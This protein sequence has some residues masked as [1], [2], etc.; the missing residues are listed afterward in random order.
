MSRSDATGPVATFD[1]GSR[2]GAASREG[3]I[4]FIGTATVLVR[5]GS[6]CFLTDPNFLHAGQRAPLGYGLH[7]TRRTDPALELDDLPPLDFVLLSHHHGDHFDP[8]VAEQLPKGTL[9]VTEPGSARKLARQGFRR[10]VALETWQSTMFAS[11]AAGLRV[12]AVPGRHAPAPLRW[13]LPRVMGS[14]LDYAIEGTPAYPIYVTGDTLLFGSSPPAGSPRRARSSSPAA[15]CTSR[16]W[17][18]ASSSTTSRT[19]TSCRSTTP[20]T[21][22]TSCSAPA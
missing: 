22:C 6:F 5:L 4:T 7:S 20:T 19:P 17:S 13:V 15:S 14:V 10:V 12:T 2:A 8:E 11:G 18:T 3:D 9:I 16:C 1:I 21:G